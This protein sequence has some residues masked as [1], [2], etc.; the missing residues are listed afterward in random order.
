M[1]V[2]GQVESLWRYPVK[3]M[4]G[5]ALAEAF[6]GFSGVYGDRLF[7]FKSV[8]APAGFPYFTGRE[9]HEMLLYHPRFRYPEKAARHANQ[10]EAQAM[11]PLLNPV[12]A[13]PADLGV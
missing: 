1:S 13:D 3:S 2:I 11:S 4:R 5:E 12:P 10:A 6:V 9:S 7:A 8:A